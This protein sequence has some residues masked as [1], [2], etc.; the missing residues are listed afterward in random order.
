M[1]S[2]RCS[3]AY[4]SGAQMGGMSAVQQMDHSGHPAATNARGFR[5]D[6]RTGRTP[7]TWAAAGG[8]VQLLL[9][10][11]GMLFDK[12]GIHTTPAAA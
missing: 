8:H 10:L 1:Q 5:N 11:H 12:A 4:E 2:S 9:Y 7:A 6:G 3:A